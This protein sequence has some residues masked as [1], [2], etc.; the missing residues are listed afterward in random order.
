MNRRD[1]FRSLLGG[2][3]V[4]LG[5]SVAPAAADPA[6]VARITEML[7]RRAWERIK[8]INGGVFDVGAGAF[9]AALELDADGPIELE[10][11]R[12]S[13]VFSRGDDYMRNPR[14]IKPRFDRLNFGG[15]QFSFDVL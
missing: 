2:A 14:N 6:E 4:A 1:L 11:A 3:A 13:A 15:Y 8:R 10:G 5:A 9:D 12:F 7:H